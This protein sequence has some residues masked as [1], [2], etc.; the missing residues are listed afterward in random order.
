[1]GGVGQDMREEAEG[2]VAQYGGVTGK[3]RPS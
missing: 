2:R 3:A 1:M